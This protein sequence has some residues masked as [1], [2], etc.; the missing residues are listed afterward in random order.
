MPQRGCRKLEKTPAR[1]EDDRRGKRQL[2]GPS[3]L[4]VTPGNEA[5]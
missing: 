3:E 1:S 2:H 4:S 5:V